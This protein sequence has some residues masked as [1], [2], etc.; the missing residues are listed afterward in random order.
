MEE[1]ARM[2]GGSLELVSAPGLGT[3]VILRLPS[4]V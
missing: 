4:G 2:A 3:E 1:R